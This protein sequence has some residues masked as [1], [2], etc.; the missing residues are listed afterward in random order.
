[1]E[2]V[3]DVEANRTRLYFP[4]VPAEE[5]RRFLKARGFR[6]ARSEGCWQRHLSASAL[7]FARQAAG[8]QGGEGK[9]G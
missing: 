5:V 8:L 2:M 9:E 3:Q 4:G 1:M 7:I 6:W